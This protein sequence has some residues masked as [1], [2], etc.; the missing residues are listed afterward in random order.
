MPFQLG[1]YNYTGV[2]PQ[3]KIKKKIRLFM[4]HESGM[5]CN[6]GYIRN[7]T[8]AKESQRSFPPTVPSSHGH[9]ARCVD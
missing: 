7:V 8:H 4:G 2:C 3:N 9:L 1:Y 5:K 6:A